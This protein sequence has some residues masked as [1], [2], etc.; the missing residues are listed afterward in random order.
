MKVQW[1]KVFYD[2]NGFCFCHHSCLIVHG[3]WVSWK[4]DHRFCSSELSVDRKPL[5]PFTHEI[6]LLLFYTYWSS[7]RRNGFITPKFVR[8]LYRFCDFVAPNCQLTGKHCFLLP[9]KAW[10]SSNFFS[11]F[12]DL[13]GGEMANHAQICNHYISLKE[14][15]AF[16]RT[17]WS[18]KSVWNHLL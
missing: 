5:F 16:E 17:S 7:A 12:T 4:W 14:H 2:I 10:D 6:I 13:C 3:A 9:T 1:F 18:I 11:M 8:P 15:V